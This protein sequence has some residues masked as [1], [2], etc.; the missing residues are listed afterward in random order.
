MHIQTKRLQRVPLNI[1]FVLFAV[2]KVEV[3]S[4]HK[5]KT[6]KMVQS[7]YNNQTNTAK[8]TEKSSNLGQ[9]VQRAVNSTEVELLVKVDFKSN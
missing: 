5:L 3:I 6:A 2:S 4:H 9:K 1:I 7:S 8:S